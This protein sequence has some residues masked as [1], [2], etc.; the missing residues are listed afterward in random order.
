MKRL[1]RFLLYKVRR[2]VSILSVC[3][4]CV[5]LYWW[6]FLTS[7]LQS[8]NCQFLNTLLLFLLSG[9]A[10]Y[11]IWGIVRSH[12]IPDCITHSPLLCLAT[13]RALTEPSPVHSLPVW[14]GNML[15]RHTGL[16][17]TELLF[18]SDSNAVQWPFYLCGSYH[19]LILETR[20]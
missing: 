19:D 18:T 17:C 9:G 20:I 14:L 10:M 6:V 7:S 16:F 8:F 13:T 11:A 1:R 12:V 15:P 5:H 3:T 4:P 2:F